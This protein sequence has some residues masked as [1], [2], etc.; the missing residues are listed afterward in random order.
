MFKPCIL[1]LL[2]GDTL[3]LPKPNLT[4]DSIFSPGKLLIMLQNPIQGFWECSFGSLGNLRGN[5]ILSPRIYFYNS[6]LFWKKKKGF[7]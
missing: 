4:Q 1:L 5:K 2:P 7:S 6:H 3:P